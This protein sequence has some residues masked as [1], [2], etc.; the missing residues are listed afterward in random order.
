MR[1]RCQHNLISSSQSR[2]KAEL[3]ITLILQ[4][5]QHLQLAEG[6][7][8]TGRTQTQVS[9]GLV[10]TGKENAGL[11]SGSCLFHSCLGLQVSLEETEEGDRSL[12][13]LGPKSSA[14]SRVVLT[15]TDLGVM[16]GM[17]RPGEAMKLGE[18]ARGL[19]SESFPAPI[20]SLLTQLCDLSL[21]GPIWEM[22]V[23]KSGGETGWPQSHLPAPSFCCALEDVY[24]T[25][26]LP[27]QVSKAL[28]SQESLQIT[29][30]FAKIETAT[31]L[32]QKKN[33]YENNSCM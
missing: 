9:S 22:K 33:S 8:G 11:A 28:C 4:M 23:V 24:R 29:L 21:K 7:S 32:C 15:H 16:V 25:I 17:Q 12:L 3:L 19:C 31:S 30:D 1:E 18:P 20:L 10:P 5:R 26:Q 27:K 14:K 6:L 2:F 13:A